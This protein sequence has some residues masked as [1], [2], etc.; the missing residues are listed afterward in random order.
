[1]N[2]PNGKTIEERGRVN[3][4]AF[5]PLLLTAIFFVAASLRAVLRR[6]NPDHVQGWGRSV[7]VNAAVR[8]NRGGWFAISRNQISR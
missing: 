5:A 1:M 4:R 3:R 2:S 7:T 6:R 8:D